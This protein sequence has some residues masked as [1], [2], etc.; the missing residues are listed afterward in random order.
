MN[1]VRRHII[2]IISGFALG[3]LMYRSI[4]LS[5][6][7]GMLFLIYSM[8]SIKREVRNAND[9]LNFKFREFL[10]CLEPLLK[11]SG[12]FSI[13]F[14][15]AYGDYERMYGQDELYPILK[16]AVLEMKM[17]RHIG[18]VLKNM[19]VKISSE[20]AGLF[21][22]CLAFTEESGG[23]IIDI[24]DRIVG[25][26]TEKIR[27]KEEIRHL[28]AA[29]KFE[30]LLIAII[31]IVILILLSA[32]VDSYMNPLFDSSGGKIVMTIAGLM[33]AASWFVGNKITEIEV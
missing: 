7:I 1:K 30:H 6:L 16:G 22:S 8:I 32:G 17:N 23:N 18:I 12:T 11:T 25:I 14:I 2:Y 20:D 19:A 15:E 21:A 4:P 29:K 26:V 9:R 24:T 31:P 5:I 10:I 3:Y 33:F 13:S 27:M 28:L